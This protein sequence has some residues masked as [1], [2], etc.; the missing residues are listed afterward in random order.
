MSTL[1]SSTGGKPADL[2][3]SSSMTRM[4]KVS[5]E[6]IDVLININS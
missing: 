4:I 6:A 5:E 3:E 1:L 2:G